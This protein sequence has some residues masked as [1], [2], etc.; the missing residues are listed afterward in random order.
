MKRSEDRAKVKAEGDEVLPFHVANLNWKTLQDI[1]QY[2][3]HYTGQET[4][5]KLQPELNQ[6]RNLYQNHLHRLNQLKMEAQIEMEKQLEVAL[7][8]IGTLD[9]LFGEK[10]PHHD[11]L[12][13]ADLVDNTRNSVKI[14]ILEDIDEL[15]SASYALGRIARYLGER[16]TFGSE[17]RIR[18]GA[19]LSEVFHEIL[20]ASSE[21]L[22][23]PALN[24][25]VHS[26]KN[27]YLTLPSWGIAQSLL[28][29]KVALE[30]A[31]FFEEARAFTGQ[32]WLENL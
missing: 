22:H 20:H 23:P 25:Y 4:Q 8:I 16:N 14:F 11:S 6:A 15:P 2:L 13:L 28:D 24:I 1:I 9:I 27:Y 3:L 12:K 26:A 32:A 29:K 19:S 10:Y 31:M 21:E 18:P 17:I 7:E 5:E 30:A